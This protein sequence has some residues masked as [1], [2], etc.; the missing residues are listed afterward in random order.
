MHLVAASALIV[1]AKFKWRSLRYGTKRLTVSRTGYSGSSR[2]TSGE[3]RGEDAAF[4][5]CVAPSQD[6]VSYFG[7]G[8]NVRAFGQ[9]ERDEGKT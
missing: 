7:G 3:E 5:L 6:A 2:G 1:Q 4:N 9:V 8:E